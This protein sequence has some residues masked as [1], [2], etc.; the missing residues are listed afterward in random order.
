[1]SELFF[2]PSVR[3]YEPSRSEQDTAEKSPVLEIF[4]QWSNGGSQ[5]LALESSQVLALEPSQALALESSQV[6]TLECSNPLD[7]T[8]ALASLSSSSSS[9]AVIISPPHLSAIRRSRSPGALTP[10]PPPPP[11]SLGADPGRIRRVAMVQVGSVASSGPPTPPPSPP[12]SEAA[13]GR[14]GPRLR[15]D[16]GTAP[17]PPPTASPENASNRDDGDS[18]TTTITVTDATTTT[19]GSWVITNGDEDPLLSPTAAASLHPN[20]ISPTPES[21]VELP[22]Q[23]PSA[24]TPTWWMY[25]YTR[26]QA[27]VRK[28]QAAGGKKRTQGVCA[29][30]M[31][32][33]GAGLLWL[34][35][36]CG[37][38]ECKG[39]RRGKGGG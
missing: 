25:F 3:S 6:L 16:T 33:T 37:V 23:E 29:G 36:C 11:T 20:T 13:A 28:P 24:P 15:I 31:R 12:I 18:P 22:E 9:S 14:R 8:V 34:V 7:G 30:L 26:P 39:A 21:S 32:C 17:P 19:N 5:V 27:A 38:C 10:P 2:T 4:G 35:T 1:M